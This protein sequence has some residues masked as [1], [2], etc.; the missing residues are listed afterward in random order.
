MRDRLGQKLSRIS[1][2]AADIERN[3]LLGALAGFAM[4]AVLV[5]ADVALGSTVNLTGTFIV[6]PFLTALWAG[7]R[8]TALVALATLAATFA[9]GVWNNNFWDSDYDARLIVVLVGSFLAIAGAW[10]RERAR[11]AAERL[12]LLN[13]VGAIADGSLPL[14]QT[15]ERVIQVIVPAFADFCMVDAIHDQRVTRSAVRVR[16]RPGS[17]DLETERYLADRE[18]SIPDWMGKPDA[19]F[20]FQP[21]FIPRFNDEDMRRLSHDDA[22]LRWLRGLGLVSSTT[23]AMRARGRLLGAL[24]FTT[25]W[26]GRSYSLDDVRFAQTFAGRV[27]LALDN[28]GLFSDLESVERRMD[29]VMSILDEAVVIRDSHGELVYANPAAASL[30]GIEEVA[31]GV[32]LATPS[33]TQAIEDRFVIRD[34]A[35]QRATPEELLGSRALAG[36]PTEPRVFRAAPRAGGAE[37]WLLARAKPILGP[38]GKALYAVTAIEDVTGVKRAEFAQRLLARAGEVLSTSTDHLEMLNALA[39]QLVPAFADWCTIEI[40]SADGRFE[41][42]AIAHVDPDRGIELAIGTPQRALCTSTTRPAP[43]RSSEPGRRGSTEP[44]WCR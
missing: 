14:D 32:E 21:R 40:P 34:E 44:S 35:G 25:A 39:E 12:G 41:P 19:P 29:N 17:L 9:S 15:L 31:P 42:L 16:G 2:R 3:D 20:P 26:S 4:L 1:A 8:I 28:A 23:V 24:T 18:P 10:A 36:H 13:A 5:A 6:V 38:E 11:A 7:T 43:R 22:D 30:M 37:R 27:A 33:A